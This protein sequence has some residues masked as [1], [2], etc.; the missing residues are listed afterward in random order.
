MKFIALT[1][2]SVLIVVFLNPIFP[3]WIVM[4][5]IGIGAFLI[6]GKPIGAFFAGAL[7]MG[8]AWLG[9]TVF[10]SMTTNS[11]LPDQM[12][13][14]MDLGSGVTLSAITGFIGFLLGG[15]SALSGC[16]L[17]NL[18]KRKPNNIYKG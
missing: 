9:Q 14:I 2:L 15:F 13:E 6:W 10:L 17:R 7:G 11:P 3:Y 1:L 8:L 16:L 12:A 5:L 18:F 4:I